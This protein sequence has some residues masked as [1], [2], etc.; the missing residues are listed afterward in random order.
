MTS[1]IFVKPKLKPT[2]YE[3]Y[4]CIAYLF[5][6]GDLSYFCYSLQGKLYVAQLPPS[7]SA[8][9]RDGKEEAKHP[10]PLCLLNPLMYTKKL[11][12]NSIFFYF[13]PLITHLQVLGPSHSYFLALSLGEYLL[14]IEKHC[15][16]L[17]LDCSTKLEFL[18]I[19]SGF[20]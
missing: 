4:I 18:L 14:A 3:V 9:G 1:H 11:R 8:R 2:V 7:T 10:P 13:A 15:R 12:C 20:P 19:Q 16:V 6:V 17:M 5:R